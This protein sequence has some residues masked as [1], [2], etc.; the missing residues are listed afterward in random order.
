MFVCTLFK[1]TFLNRSE[2]NFAHVSPVFWK[3]PQDTYGPT[4][5]HLP[6]HF[7]LFRCGGLHDAAHKWLPAPRGIPHS[8]ISVA[9][10]RVHV[11]SRALRPGALHILTAR[12]VFCSWCVETAEKITVSTRVNVEII[13]RVRV[14]VSLACGVSM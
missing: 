10:T 5:F 6:H 14:C 3:R 8:V 4:I 1:S 9:P 7:D 12:V 13:Y 11:T 2:P